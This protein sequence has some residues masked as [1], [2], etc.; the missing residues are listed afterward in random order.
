VDDLRMR[1]LELSQRG[2][3][4]SQI[5]ISLALEAQ[6]KE[7]TD[8]V[9]AM[10]GLALGAGTGLGT[11]GALEGAACVIALYTGKGRD[12]EEEVEELWLMLAELWEWFEKEITAPYGGVKCDDILRDGTPMK[13]RCGPIVAASYSKAIQLLIEHGIDP[14]EP[15][16]E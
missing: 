15:R 9:R 3:Y 11:C 12:D 7:N 4:C 13:Q 8:L 6:G 5:L 14:S 2:Y 16:G 1:M 10:A